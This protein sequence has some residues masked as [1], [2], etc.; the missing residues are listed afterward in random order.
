MLKLVFSSRNSK[1]KY[2][3]FYDNLRCLSNITCKSFETIEQA[4]DWAWHQPDMFMGNCDIQFM[5]YMKE[6]RHPILLGKRWDF[7]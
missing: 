1:K 4:V 2:V 5:D 7:A 3:V 6:V